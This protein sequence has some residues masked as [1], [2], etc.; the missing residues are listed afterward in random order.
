[1]NSAGSTVSAP[2]AVNSIIPSAA[3][4]D[5]LE[6]RERRTAPSQIGPRRMGYGLPCAHCRTYYPADQSACPICGGGERVSATAVAAPRLPEESLPDTATLEEEREKFLREFKAQ[7]YATHTQI[8][9][10]TSFRCEIEANHPEGFEPAAVCDSCYK[11]VQQRADLMEAALHMD[12]NDA[13]KIVY[14]AVWANPSDSNKTY[15]NA[16]HALLSELRR[17][18]GIANVLGPNQSLTH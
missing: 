18:A 2:A 14:D 7:I 16:A 13:A 11:S 8:N 15:Q 9:A 6:R 10:A 3:E 12:V 1:M 5:H 17:R 4:I